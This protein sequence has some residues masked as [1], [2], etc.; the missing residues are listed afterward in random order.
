MRRL[1]ATPVLIVVFLLCIAGIVGLGARLDKDVNASEATPAPTAGVPLGH[2]TPTAV[3][4]HTVAIVKPSPTVT[5]TAVPTAI[6]PAFPPTPIIAPAPEQTHHP[7]IPSITPVPVKTAVA[8]PSGKSPNGTG[9]GAKTNAP[10]VIYAAIGASDAVGVGATDPATQSWVADLGRR[11]PRGSVVHNFGISG[12]LLDDA[13]AKEMPGAIASQPTLVTVW[14]AVNDIN[15]QVPLS[16]Y[17]H[18]LAVLLH[19]LQ[20]QTHAKVFVGNVPDLALLPIYKANVNVPT[21]VIDQT[22]AQW[23]SGIATIA[24]RYGATVVD[25]YTPSVTTLPLHPEYVSADGF[26]PSTAG[27]VDEANVFWKVILAHKGSLPLH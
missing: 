9:T 22:V 7:V 3:P 18:Q 12:I 16:T 11:L 6:P 17:E 14:N 25:L 20:T 2:A 13:L 27:Y 8:L 5:A 26:H 19:A 21:V 1:T 4:H 10:P 23:N 24:R 15:A